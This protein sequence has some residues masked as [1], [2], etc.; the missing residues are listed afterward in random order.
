MTAF[1]Y[2]EFQRNIAI[3][4]INEEIEFYGQSEFHDTYPINSYL[5]YLKN[6]IGI[7]KEYPITVTHY[8]HSGNRHEIKKMNMDEYAKDMDVYVFKKPWNKLREFH[9]IM[10]IKEFIDKLSFGK[11][12]KE[13]DI[14]KNKKILKDEVCGGLKTKRFGKNKCEVIYDEKNMLIKSI[15]CLHFNN[16]IGLYE[17]DWDL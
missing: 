13:K 2:Y 11:K 5:L 8:D 3:Q 9:K 1:D 16:K 6:R 4:G 7:D 15:S 14:T 12:S 10:K 17:I